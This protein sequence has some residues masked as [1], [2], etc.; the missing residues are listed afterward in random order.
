MLSGLP[1]DKG[2]L[3]LRRRVAAPSA[4]SVAWYRRASAENGPE[5]LA[6]DRFGCE[7]WVQR[8]EDSAEQMVIVDCAEVESALRLL[9]GNDWLHVTWQR[10]NHR[11]RSPIR[12][13]TFARL[14]PAGVRETIV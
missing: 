12:M 8:R 2:R 10:A 11:A 6:H 5:H 7:R 14:E 3:H 13:E 4:R 1:V 9:A